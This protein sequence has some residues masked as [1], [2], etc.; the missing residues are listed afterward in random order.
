MK[1]ISIV[2]GLVLLGM[3][4]SGMV[5]AD[6]PPGGG[7]GGGGFG[8]GQS[9]DTIKQRIEQRIQENITRMQQMLTCV[10]DAQ[11]RESLRNCRPKG[12]RRRGDRRMGPQGGQSGG[13][14]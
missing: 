9:L 3:T 2:L 14:G 12:G 6:T 11:D 5:L 10:Q 8:N 4:G 13:Q 7:P 1:R